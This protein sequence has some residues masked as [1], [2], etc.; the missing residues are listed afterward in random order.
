MNRHFP[1]WRGLLLLTLLGIA[2]PAPAQLR[3]RLPPEEPQWLKMKFTEVSIGVYTEGVFERTRFA[4]SSPVEYSRLFAGPS[5]GLK[6]NGS[7]YH[8]NFA[9]LALSGE[10]A[11]GWANETV[12]SGTSFTRSELQQLGNLQSTLYLL[13]NK[14]YAS[15]LFANYDHTYR[16][17]DFFN[18]TTVDS[19]RY[20]GQTGYREGPI[21]VTITVWNLNEEERNVLGVVTV[22]NATPGGTNVVSRPVYGMSSLRQTS[23]SLE[24]HNDRASGGTRFTYGMSDYDRGDF[25]TTGGSTDHTIGLSDNETFGRRRQ[26]TWNNDVGYAMRRFTDA[27]SDDFNANS[28]LGIEHTPS[29]SSSYGANYYHSTYAD[30][31]S[32]NYDGSASVRHQLYQSLTSTLRIDGQGYDASGPGG[33]SETARFGASLSEGYTKRLSPSAN[34]TLNG[35]LGLS[36]TKVEQ[37]GSVITIIDE[38][39]TFPTG[40]G[41]G[42]VGT[43]SLNQPNV[44]AATIIVRDPPQTLVYLEGVDYTVTRNGL[45]TFLNR[46]GGSRIPAGGSVLV[47]Y[48]A[49]PSPS[50]SYDTL[51]GLLQVRLEFWNG[52]LAAY[53]RMNSVQNHGTPG[54]IVQDLS[55]FALGADTSW[56]FLRAGAEYEIY[57]S[58]FSSYRSARLYQSLMFRPDEA[59]TL[60]LDFL[61]TW[62]TYLDPR[63]EENLFSFI[64]RYHRRLTA[65]LGTDLEG[66]FSVRRG[67]GVDQTLATLRPGLDFAMGKLSLKLGYDFQYARYLDSEERLKH[68]FF[69][70]LKRTF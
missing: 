56:R 64:T 43:F 32:D 65:H 39:H 62:T 54:L 42:P 44:D 5:F 26:I 2:L 10:M 27:P 66:G 67:P 58:N 49:T 8:P 29:V 21:P 17:Y 52:L 15:S 45:L 50:G 33:S 24:A 16:D 61:E 1:H 20:G 55:A 4:G 28:R 34:L 31:R 38:P 6:L 7:I 60:N 9:R 3:N 63:R 12:D 23:V 41:G 51:N 25:G 18:R 37:D 13:N 48:N 47:T 35:T 53:G 36:H 69:I 14:P 57:D 68:M 40:V 11:V 70:R 22:T 46:I 59:S 30:N 19:W